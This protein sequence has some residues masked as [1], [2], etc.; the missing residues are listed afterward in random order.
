MLPYQFDQLLVVLSH[1]FHPGGD[2]GVLCG[3][4]RQAIQRLVSSFVRFADLSHQ[5]GDFTFILSSD[6]YWTPSQPANS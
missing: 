4:P 6:H 1:A 2:E 5:A 3:A